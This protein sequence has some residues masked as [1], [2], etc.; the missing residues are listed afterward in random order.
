VLG[1]WRLDDGSG[2]TAADASGNSNPGHLTTGAA[3]TSD[4]AVNSVPQT[5]TADKGTL[6]L[7]G[8]SG[9]VVIPDSAVLHPASAITLEAWVK[10]T[11]SYTTAA[12]VGRQDASSTSDSFQIGFEPDLFFSVT[13]AKGNPTTLDT[14]VTP[15]LNQWHFIAGTWDGSVMRL[16]FDGV[17]VGY[18]TFAGPIGYQGSNPILIGADNDGPGS[19]PNC[20]YFPGEIDEVRIS[21][22]AL[23]PADFL[24][25][26]P[27]VSGLSV[28]T[29]QNTTAGATL[30]MTVTAQDRYGNPATGYRGTVHFTSTD[31]HAIL[32]ANYTFSPADNGMHTF[33]VTLRTSGT[34]SI[35]ATDTASG[36]L[37]CDDTT[38]A[39]LKYNAFTGA[40]ISTFASSS[41][42][43][44]AV[45]L[46]Y[47]PDGN[48]YV[49]GEGSDNVV[50][51][52]GATGAYLNTFVPDGTGGLASA[53]GLAFGVDGDLYVSSQAPNNE[54]VKQF[55]GNTGAYLGEFVPAGSG[56]VSPPLGIAFG[57]DGNFY[58]ASRD[59]NQVLRYNGLT[60]AFMGAFASGGGLTQPVAFTWGPDGNLYVISFQANGQ[61][62]RYNGQTG[63]FMDVFAQGGGLSYPNGAAFG[64]DGNLYVAGQQ[65]GIQRYDGQTGAFLNTF[66]P[67]GSS[68]LTNPADLIFHVLTGSQTGIT[69]SAGPA[70]VLTVTGFPS[71]VGAGTT[72]GFT[73]SVK[74]AYGNLASGYRGIIHFTS[75]D[76]LA[77]LPSD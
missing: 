46:A 35:T 19:N 77:S 49:T 15:A 14:N 72:H 70:K 55:D 51:F 41:Q 23:N 53:H 30:S 21:S 3:F 56:G 32:P 63:T 66:V 67:L 57:P 43:T 11:G 17:Q 73:V 10:F 50:A 16:Y 61:V 48:L 58:V 28:A 59:T 74:D 37:V 62:L 40:P 5:G 44:D 22:V 1:Y 69:V 54:D 4:T 20:C 76:T 34:Q 33:K 65:S 52:S 8:V 45:T 26:P 29:T 38:G 47:G 13:D 12:V 9:A 60:G 75:P 39:V 6:S 24:M 36:L 7:D 31:P 68:G 2:T 71:S 27:D 18:T 42:L 25:R 64:P